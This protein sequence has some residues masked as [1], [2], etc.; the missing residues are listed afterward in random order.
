MGRLSTIWRACA[1]AATLVTVVAPVAVAAA[2]PSSEPPASTPSSGDFVLP[3][4]W[5]TLVDDTDTISVAVPNTW[6]DINTTP[7]SNADGTVMPSIVAATNIQIYTDTF[8]EP[9]V[10]YRAMPYDA[11]QQGVMDAYGLTGG[12]RLKNFEPYDDGAFVGLHGIWSDCGTELDPEWHQIVASPASQSFTVVLQIQITGPDETADL[13]NVLASFN[14]TPR[15]GSTPGPFTTTTIPGATTTTS[16]TVPAE[17]TTSVAPTATTTV[18]PTPTIITAPVTAAPLAQP[19]GSIP[20]DFLQV[21]DELGVLS[22]HVPPTWTDRNTASFTG[23]QL[24]NA[25][26]ISATPDSNLFFPDE[27]E[28]DTWSVPGLYYVGLPF[29]ADVE[30]VMNDRGELRGCT[31]QGAQPYSDGVFTGFIQELTSC[32]GTGTRVV[33]IVAN[34]ADNSRTI[35]LVLQLTGAAD[36]AAIYDGVLS[37]FNLIGPAS[38]GGATTTT[39]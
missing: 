33:S 9:G 22:V 24:T 8:D 17:P 4:G 12:C 25:P 28:A 1:L 14:F 30:S 38:A 27:G 18:L 15:G 23:N 31:P 13:D 10:L 36:D 6:V 11:D 3:A 5:T 26:Y 7:L 19:S 2:P 39:A 16:T 20:A 32:G 37:S 34:A 29:S 21:V 35:L